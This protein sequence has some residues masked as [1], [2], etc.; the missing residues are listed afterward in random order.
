[1]H[2]RSQVQSSKSRLRSTA[3]VHSRTGVEFTHDQSR[4]VIG[5]AWTPIATRVAAVQLV[6]EWASQQPPPL[7]TLPTPVG[8][9]EVSQAGLTR[10]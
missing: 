2:R 6:G 1:M 9:G 3:R 8:R 5:C 10:D 4:H 7:S